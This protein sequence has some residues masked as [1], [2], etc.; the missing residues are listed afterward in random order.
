MNYELAKKLKEAGFPQVFN[1]PFNFYYPDEE[2]NEGQ[3]QHCSGQEVDSGCYGLGVDEGEIED[4]ALDYK[5]DEKPVNI[6]I[7]VPTLSE[8][9]EACGRQ[10]RL[11]NSEPDL[12]QADNCG[13]FNQFNDS[14]LVGVGQTPEEAVSNLW[15]ELNSPR[16]SK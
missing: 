3:I 6:L 16:L 1:P 11:Q 8:L 13:D 15:L 2:D 9:I 10:F 12:W 4:W 5:Y 14:H 7:K